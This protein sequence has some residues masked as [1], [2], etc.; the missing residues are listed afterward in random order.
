MI[1]LP[2]ENYEDSVKDNVDYNLK[3]TTINPEYYLNTAILKALDCLTK[4]DFKNGIF[5]YRILV[6]F[7]EGLCRSTK[8]LTDKY[9]EDIKKFTDSK[10]YKGTSEQL[11]HA[12]LA[13]KKLELIMSEINKSGKLNNPLSTANK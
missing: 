5:Q 12:R 4:D 9:D 7:I 11:K 1:K 13:N 3:D 6:E 8:K 10:D 2:S